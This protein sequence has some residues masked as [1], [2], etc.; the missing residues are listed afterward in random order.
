[1]DSRDIVVIVSNMTYL[2]YTLEETAN[3][4][5]LSETVLV[6]LSQYFKVPRSAYEEVGY[7]SFKGDLA[8]TDQDIAFFRQVK[9][10]L[11]AGENLDEVKSRIR[12]DQPLA[13]A[14]VPPNPTATTMPPT[15]T[16]IPRPPVTETPQRRIVPPPPVTRR[17]Q[18]SLRP[19]ASQP[20]QPPTRSAQRPAT[21]TAPNLSPIGISGLREVESPQTFQQAAERSFERYKSQHRTGLS[22]VFE[23]MLKD[24][25]PT[26]AKSKGS[27][28]ST[29]APPGVNQAKS[30]TRPDKRV[31]EE[32]THGPALTDAA[33][34]GPLQGEFDWEQL[35]AQASRQPRSLNINLKNAAQILKA[36]ALAQ[37]EAFQ[38]HLG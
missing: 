29:N 12:A 31:V 11:L 2:C 3:R 25:G 18:S 28:Y 26:S 23:K 22:K 34:Q 7:L 35:I 24:I 20:M 38:N 13:A 33:L 27:T 21:Q 19:A 6:R 17:E 9:E 32:V 1:M 5:N 36:K 15:A 8:F 14:P 16:P 4:L 10:R 30:R 37:P